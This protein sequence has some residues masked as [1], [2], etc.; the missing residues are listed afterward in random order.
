MTQNGPVTIDLD[1]VTESYETDLVDK[2]RQFGVEGDLFETW[3]PDPNPVKSIINLMDASQ[4]AGLPAHLVVVASRKVLNHLA[5]ANLQAELDG[6][7]D[8]EILDQE[9]S[10]KIVLSEFGEGRGSKSRI[11]GEFTSS[12]VLDE[13]EKKLARKDPQTVAGIVSQGKKAAE[14]PAQ[15][16]LYDLSDQ[17]PFKHEGSINSEGEPRVVVVKNDECALELQVDASCHL[18]EQAMFSDAKSQGLAPLLNRL[19]EAIENRPIQDMSDHAVA[20]LEYQIR[21]TQ[22]RPVPGIV[23]AQAVD[24]RLSELQALVRQA[25]AEYREFTG[26]QEISNTF[27]DDAQTTWLDLPDSKKMSQA[28]EVLREEAQKMGNSTT[29][30]DVIDIEYNVRVLARFSG[31]LALPETDKQPIMMQFEQALV[32]NLDSRLELFL[33]PELDQSTL[34]R[35]SGEE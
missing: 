25:L 18:V 28:E 20:R 35:L 5:V 10:V 2:L 23:L 22:R 32:D 29:E 9:D 11:V 33:E 15:N 4:V 31:V 6:K 21:N 27:D 7:A 3:V 13:P 1:E 30:V 12:F 14:Q 8:I 26:Y 34:R 19:C 24:S 16:N 17:P